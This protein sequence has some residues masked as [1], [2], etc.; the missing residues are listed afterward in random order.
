MTKKRDFGL[1]NLLALNG[2]RYFVDEK[3][4]F[5]VIFKV[6]CVALKPE[7]PHGLKYSLV[8]LNAKG[9]RVVGFDNAHVARQG[10][11]PGKKRSLQLDHKHIGNRVTPYDFK[12]ALTLLQDF[13]KEVDKRI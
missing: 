10:S 4:E 13:W 9:E 6:K 11:G 3:G 5:E 2:D 8:L 12:D 7:T 1:E